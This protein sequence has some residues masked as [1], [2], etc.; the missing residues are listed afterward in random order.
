MKS[1]GEL[2]A[3]DIYSFLLENK[4][5]KLIIS[6]FDADRLYS[7][8]V[9]IKARD[10]K[11]FKE[12]GLNFEICVVRMSYHTEFIPNPDSVNLMA[13]NFYLFE[14]VKPTPN[15]KYTAYIIEQGNS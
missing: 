12:L 13:Q 9:V 6:Q 4:K 14:L 3:Q 7:H 10:K 1:Y 11:L 2:S 15:K 8:L 5:V